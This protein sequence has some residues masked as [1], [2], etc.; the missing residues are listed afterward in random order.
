[1]DFAIQA[2]YRVKIKESKK[3]GKY[4]DLDRELKKKNYGT[5]RW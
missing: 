4:Q 5:W 1:M 3:R 2:D